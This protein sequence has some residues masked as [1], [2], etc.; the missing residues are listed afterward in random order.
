[1]EPTTKATARPKHMEHQESF[2]LRGLRLWTM[3]KRGSGRTL[4]SE[5]V[6]TKPGPYPTAI[7]V[8]VGFFL[9]ETKLRLAQFY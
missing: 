3:F 1:M 6:V 4:F 5:K 8:V 7:Q 9:F 2:P